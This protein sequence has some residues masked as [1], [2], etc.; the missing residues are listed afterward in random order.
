MQS[1]TVVHKGQVPQQAARL[2]CRTQCPLARR[3]LVVNLATITRTDER[4]P[5]SRVTMIKTLVRQYAIQRIIRSRLRTVI[6]PAL[7][8]GCVFRTVFLDSRHWLLISDPSRSRSF[9]SR[10]PC[11]GPRGHLL[12]HSPDDDLQYGKLPGIGTSSFYLPLALAVA[13]NARSSSV[14]SSLC[15]LATRTRTQQDLDDGRRALRSVWL[16]RG[17]ERLQSYPC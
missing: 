11:R 5:C 1:F 3:H 16:R 9:P 7:I 17:Q 13:A 12:S 8:C 15:W 14:P 4:H 2:V 10:A 6:I